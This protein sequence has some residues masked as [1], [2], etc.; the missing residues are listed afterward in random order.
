MLNYF[1]KNKN[2]ILNLSLKKIYRHFFLNDKKFTSYYSYLKGFI[3][4][5]LQAKYPHYKKEDFEKKLDKLI[6]EADDYKDLS[7]ELNVLFDPKFNEDLEF[8]YK[9]HEN[10]IFFKFITYSMNTKLISDKYSQVYDFAINNLSEPLKILEIGGGLP[11]G[12]IYNIWKKDTNFLE[13]FTYVDANLL[14]SEFV[15]WYCE[16][17]KITNDVKL[18]KPAKTPLLEATKFNF[19]FAKDIFE[20]LDAPEILI[21]YLILNTKNNK[22]LLCLD[23]EHKG[24]KIGQHISP[25]LPILKE[26]LIKNNFKVI[27]EFKEVHVWKKIN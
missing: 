3:F 11:H 21:D 8:H 5:F 2:K 4:E 24:E 1:K 12:L 19:V 23:L 25:N 13:N 18:F 15:K 17:I 26:R 6:S 14:H 20:H 10:Y 27:K 7:G 16:K 9:Y 22:T